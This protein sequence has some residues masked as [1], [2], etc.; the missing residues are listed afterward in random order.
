MQ[1]FLFI[2]FAESSLPF[3]E[4]DWLLKIKEA[5]VELWLGAGAAFLAF[6]GM[7]KRAVKMVIRLV[8]AAVMA[9]LLF[10]GWNWYQADPNR[11]AR[12]A[13][14]LSNVDLPQLVRSASESS[15]GLREQFRGVLDKTEQRIGTSDDNYQR[16]L[17]ELEK[18]VAEKIRDAS[19]DDYSSTRDELMRIRDDIRERLEE[20]VQRADR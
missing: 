15:T 2:L 1:D 18:A 16:A 6:F 17:H 10:L 4:P 5:G 13:N 19:G 14:W 20:A 7:I 3:A 8:S 9:I 12:A 11:T